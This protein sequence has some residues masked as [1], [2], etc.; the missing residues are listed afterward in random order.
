MGTVRLLEA[1]R[2]SNLKCRFYQASSSEMFG[3]TPP[4]QS[5]ATVFHPRSPYACAKVYAH[6]DHCELPGK[7]RM[8]A[9][10]TGSSSITSRRAGAKLSS[11]VKSPWAV[12]RIKGWACQVSCI[13]G[14]LD[15]RR[16]WG[17]ARDYVGSYV[18]H[19][20]TGP[21]RR[22]RHRNG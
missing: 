12:A 11:H 21:G 22:L 14:N 8:H 4:P 7:L 13:I 5:E 2:R 20:P 6:Q 18:A 9:S 15:A 17:F 10:C 19:A 3:S 16:D 1:I